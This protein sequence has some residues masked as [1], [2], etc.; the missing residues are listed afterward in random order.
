MKKEVGTMIMIFLISFLIM[1]CINMYLGKTKEVK[2]HYLTYFLPY[3]NDEK[4]GL[5]QFYEN[6]DY[7]R[8]NLKKYFI[9]QPVRV[10]YVT[11]EQNR[12][13]QYLNTLLLA[14]SKIENVQNVSYTSYDLLLRDVA[15]NKLQF[16]LIPLPI[17]SNAT[18]QNSKTTF[19]FTQLNYVFPFYRRY[20]YIFTKRRSGIQNLRNIPPK[21]KIG[22][23]SDDII[24]GTVIG[25][26]VMNFLKYIQIRDY[27]FIEYKTPKEMFQAFMQN[28]FDIMFHR[29]YF[30]DK[31]LTD[32]ITETIQEEIYLLPF[33]IPR[34]DVFYSMNYQY[35]PSYIDLNQL[36]PLY[37][38][39]K[40]DRYSWNKYKPDIKMLSWEEYLVTNKMVSDD[41]IYDT[42][43]TYYGSID[44]INSIPEI[45]NNPLS[46]VGIERDTNMP[47]L[48]HNGAY[49]F[50]REKGFITNEPNE[51]CKYLIG[52]KE[53]T[54]KTLEDNNLILSDPQL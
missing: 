22:V 17:I 23:V 46:K 12:T 5:Y 28:D 43:K 8:L 16:G 27:E 4:N 19:D 7:K 24:Y 29:G 18:F 49:K 39:K 2:E 10:G 21:T 6:E 9:Y 26:N 32:F 44:F 13:I 45:K 30:P 40:F 15:K 11:N 48:Y 25:T 54:K 1:I 41:I 14:K 38:P 42:I 50:Y 37:L 34:E 3:Y 20:L 52:V 36:S 47:I 31:E 53:C 51:N 35:F 33:E